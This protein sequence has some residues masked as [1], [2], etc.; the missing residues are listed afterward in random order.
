[1]AGGPETR[2]RLARQL[3]GVGRR[4]DQDVREIIT[5]QSRWFF[6][7]ARG[8]FQRCALRQDLGQALAFGRWSPLADVRIEAGFLVVH[9]RHEHPVRAEIAP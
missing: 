6:D 2:A 4:I 7:L 3:H 5:S 9:P 1:M 8:R